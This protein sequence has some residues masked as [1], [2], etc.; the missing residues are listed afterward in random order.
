MP[1][2]L[3]SINDVLEDLQRSRETATSDPTAASPSDLLASNAFIRDARALLADSTATDRV[4]ARIEASKQRAASAQA[5][6]QS[7]V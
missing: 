4:G 7:R 2:T 6:L 3:L 5:S 1:Q